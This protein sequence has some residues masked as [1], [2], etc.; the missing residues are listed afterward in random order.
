MWF[1]STQTEN[2][3]KT[4]FIHLIG[5]CCLVKLYNKMYLMAVECNEAGVSVVLTL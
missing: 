1:V 5:S 3:L 4:T 2:E